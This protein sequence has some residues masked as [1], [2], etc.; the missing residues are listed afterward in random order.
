MMISKTEKTS[1]ISLVLIS[2]L[3]L[4]TGCFGQKEKVADN[5]GQKDF[6]T[7]TTD[8][9]EL[10]L[11]INGKPVLYAKDFEEQKMMAQ[12]SN[13][14]VNMILQMMP[15]AAYSMLFK[16]IQAGLL[17]K[18]W[19]ADQGIDKTPEFIKQRRQLQDQIDLQL[20]MKYFE[21]AHPIAVSDHEA[22][23]FYK[24]K[25]D[26]IPGLLVAPA[27]VEIIYATFATKAQA[28]VFASKVRDGSEKHMK[29][30][31]KE[32]GVKIET[33]DISLNSTCNEVLKETVL[34]TTKVPAKE[35]V[36]IDEN[37]YWV[38]GMVKKT[39]AQYHA[40]ENAQ[41][42]E[43]M[44]KA[45]RDAKRETELTQ[46]IQDLHAQYKVVENSAYFESKK[47]NQSQTL[48]NAQEMIMQM[49]QQA[50]QDGDDDLLDDKF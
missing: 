10:L 50:S 38:V 47:E 24:E 7:E 23:Q 9:G 16:S 48:Q 13:Q 35:I 17:M 25:R 1:V 29:A 22:L 20:C 3:L 26:Q 6:S 12:Q 18:E 2:S 37:A 40:F 33:M 32:T 15:E 42:K 4:L 39:E 45:C 30:A 44:K 31:A 36:K 21:E 43:F 46:Q 11:S 34:A 41:V 14:Q 49:Q 5:G 27:S 8:K 19:I 28:E